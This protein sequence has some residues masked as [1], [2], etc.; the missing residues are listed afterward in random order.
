MS[1]MEIPVI[2]QDWST[3]HGQQRPFSPLQAL[4][5][6]R[7]QSEPTESVVGLQPLREAVACC[8]EQLCPEDR[9]LLE[10]SHVERVTVRELASRIGLHKSYTHRLVKRA[11][12]RLRAVLLEDAV[13]LLYLGL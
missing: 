9:Y 8:I 5:E 4:M 12:L 3:V 2:F 10:A 13:I 1:R 7:P 6:A 11:E